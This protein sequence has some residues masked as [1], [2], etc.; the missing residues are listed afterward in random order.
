M[1]QYS[2]NQVLQIFPRVTNA[3]FN[4]YIIRKRIKQLGK[5]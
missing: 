5:Q 3:I 1:L 4:Q 2:L